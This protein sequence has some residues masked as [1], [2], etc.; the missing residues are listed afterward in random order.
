LIL[1]ETYQEGVRSMTAG[2]SAFDI[3]STD[4]TTR[5]VNIAKKLVPVGHMKLAA[6]DNPSLNLNIPRK[7]AEVGHW[8]AS[9]AGT[10]NFTPGSATFNSKPTPEA[11]VSHCT[12]SSSAPI[13][14]TTV[15]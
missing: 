5:T 1:D 3:T 11:S 7:A 4:T 15:S 2:V 8:V 9:Q 10:M 12:Q 13:S 6:S 14:N